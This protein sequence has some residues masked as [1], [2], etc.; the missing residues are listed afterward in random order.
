M[1]L[2]RRFNL[3]AEQANA[4]IQR[5]PVIVKKGLSLERARSLVH[6]LEEIGAKTRIERVFL[7]HE[8]PV[9]AQEATQH[10]R[11]SPGPKETPSESTCYWE[12]MENLGFVKAFFG[13]IGDVLFH[14]SHFYSRMPLERGL[15]NPLIF[16]LVMGVLGGMF[17]LLYQFLMMQF[18]G[19]MFGTEAFS[20]FSMPMMIGWAIGLPIATIIGVFIL[21]GVLHVCL[22]I[23]RGN[24]KGFES[25]FRVVAYA[26]SVQVFTII[27]F[28]GGLVAWIWALVLG[29]IGFRESHGISTGRA[30]LAV[31]LP[32]IVILVFTIFLLAMMLPLILKTVSEAVGNF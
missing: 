17:G 1:G 21:S 24:K 8:Q 12:D 28:L 26:M 3:T 11:I 9:P 7:E 18:F 20:E 29:V 2:Q 22:M 23:V 5:T 16:A 15:I 13:T 25:T 14:P 6:H 27:P 10:D 30:A 4:L 19:S 31:F 32:L